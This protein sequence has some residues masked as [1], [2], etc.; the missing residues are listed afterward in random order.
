MPPPHAGYAGKEHASNELVK[1]PAE[2]KR[3]FY[4]VQDDLAV[5]WA[6]E[7]IVGKPSFNKSTEA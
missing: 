3:P 1:H 7:R 6:V 4:T 2:F 5:S